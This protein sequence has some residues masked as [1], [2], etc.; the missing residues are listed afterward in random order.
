MMDELGPLLAASGALLLLGIA[1]ISAAMLEEEE[2]AAA[3][4]HRVLIVAEA[5]RDNLVATRRPRPITDDGPPQKKRYIKWDRDRAR[6]CIMDDYLGDLP[7]FSLDDFKRIFR[8]SRHRYEEIRSYLCRT[9]SFFQAGYDAYKRQ[10]VSADAKI[11]ITLK[12]LAYGCSINSFRDYFQMGES[13]AMM[14]VKK[15]T[16]LMSS[17]T[18]FRSR[19]LPAITPADAKQLEALHHKQHGVRGMIGSLD[20]SHFVWA[21]CPVAFH[22]QFQGKEEKRTIVMEAVC[23]YNR[24]AWHTVFG[25]SGVLNDIN[26]WDASLLH[27][28]FCDESFSQM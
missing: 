13:T 3:A 25:Y 19:F 8:I 15:V 10:K 4:A 7:R 12:Y 17:S 18:E 1:S 16:K 6:H 20:C 11:L 21:N 2:E 27:K 28:A 14:C 26:I 5:V 23:D 24:F 22:G 9:D